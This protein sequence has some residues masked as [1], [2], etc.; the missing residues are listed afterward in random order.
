M[1]IHYEV[2]S[3]QLCVWILYMLLARG[4]TPIPQGDLLIGGLNIEGDVLPLHTMVDVKFI[5]CKYLLSLENMSK[6]VHN[7]RYTADEVLAI[8]LDTGSDSEL[9]EL[10]E[11]D[12]QVKELEE[13][14][15][16]PRIELE[17]PILPKGEDYQNIDIHLE[18]SRDDDK[19]NIRNDREDTVLCKLIGTPPK[20]IIFYLVSDIFLLKSQVKV[21][22]DLKPIY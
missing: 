12:E 14:P 17:D 5:Q 1:C 9:S 21:L 8:I 11:E 13:N 4:L 3:V 6:L 20:I 10:D 16:Q 15:I 2:G 18:I 22:N 19:G 7:K